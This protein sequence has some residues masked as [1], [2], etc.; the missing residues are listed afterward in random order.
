[1]ELAS[2]ALGFGFSLLAAVVPTILYALL[3]WWGDRYEKEPWGL[4]AVTFV[5][6]AVPAILIS[7]L[8]ETL[9]GAPLAGLQ[10][11]RLANLLEASGLAPVVEETAKALALVGL[12]LFFRREFDN[13]LDGVIYGALVGIGFGMTEN[14]LYFLSS[15]LE[16]GW[17]GWGVVVFLRTVLF[18]LNH[19]FFTAFS[20]AGLGAARLARR[21]WQR[22]LLP[23]LGLGAAMT[24]HGLHNLGVSLADISLVGL[25]LSLLTDGGGLLVLFVV[26]LLAWRQERLWIETEL[27]DEVDRL[28]TASEYSA[29]AA[30]ARRLR[31]WWA[32][33]R[34]GGRKEARRQGRVHRLLTE[35]AFRKHRLR[36]LG[37]EDDVTLLADIEHLRQEIASL[38]NGNPA[39]LPSA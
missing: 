3:I 12:F 18:G 33:W 6:G 21:G 10:A 16:S 22:W 25:L 27:G 32:A 37:D 36:V 11:E 30:Y 19:A 14:L 4:L 13:V 34:R 2:S 29:A 17:R 26:V 20:G 35:L 24:F 7:L 1:M 5:W 31:L 9:F 28:L 15:F 38:R 8:A 39:S 23:L